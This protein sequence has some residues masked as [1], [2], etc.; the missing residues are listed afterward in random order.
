M[1]MQKSTFNRFC[2]AVF[3]YDK[4]IYILIAVP[5]SA[6][7]VW[8]CYCKV[9]NSINLSTIKGLTI[10]IQHLHTLVLWN[11]SLEQKIY[12]ELAVFHFAP[13][14][15]ILLH[16]APFCSTVLQNCGHANTH[17]KIPSIIRPAKD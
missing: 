10:C 17:S 7:K 5:Q 2:F 12:I 6:P 1:F 11:H 14:C 9:Q 8:L 3:N 15:S 13:L 16:R 4:A